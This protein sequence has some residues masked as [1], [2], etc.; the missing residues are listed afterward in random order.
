M[1]LRGRS[2]NSAPA[3]PSRGDQMTKFKI[4]MKGTN[5]VYRVPEDMIPSAARNLIDVGRA[6]LVEEEPTVKEKIV[7]TATKVVTGA[8]QA[9]RF[10]FN[11]SP[12]QNPAPNKR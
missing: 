1:K 5:H 12:Y 10:A 7:E 4:A 11:F 6:T 2:A 3:A 8:R 9:A